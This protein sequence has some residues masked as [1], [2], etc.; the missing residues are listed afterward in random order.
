MML[1]NVAVA[2]MKLKRS[3]RTDEV[4]NDFYIGGVESPEKNRELK[5]QYKA[6]LDADAARLAEQGLGPKPTRAMRESMSRM[7]DR[8]GLTGLNI[9]G[10][11]DVSVVEASRRK[12]KYKAQLDE[13]ALEADYLRRV[14]KE[15]TKHHFLGKAP[16]LQEER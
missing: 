8:T 7:I 4:K 15:A 10:D 14:E 1:E 16:Y 2:N 13:Q 9:G 11:R 12:E 5:H 6:M 3:D